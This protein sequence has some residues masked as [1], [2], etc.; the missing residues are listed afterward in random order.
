MTSVKLMNEALKME[1]LKKAEKC[2]EENL[3]WSQINKY[4]FSTH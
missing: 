2:F 1:I 3:H 4:L